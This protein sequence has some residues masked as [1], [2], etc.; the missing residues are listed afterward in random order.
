MSGAGVNHLQGDA[1][2]DTLIGDGLAVVADYP[3]FRAAGS[4]VVFDASV[5]I[6]GAV[7]ELADGLG[8]IDRLEG[9]EE[10]WI[11][12]SRD[13]ANTLIGSAG[14]DQLVGYSGNDL[15]QGGDGRDSLFGGDGDDTM[16]GGPG[17]DDS[18]VGGGRQRQP[19][20][21]LGSG[22]DTPRSAATGQDWARYGFWDAAADVACD[23]SVLRPE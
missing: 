9:I 14:E 20:A 8:G 16:R 18:L 2:N 12:G 15:L 22:N 13:H 11:Y 10:L 4:G 17:G 23:G 7:V 21:R 5:F 3:F 19:F 1:G 6:P